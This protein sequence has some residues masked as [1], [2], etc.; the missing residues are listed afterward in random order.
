MSGKTGLDLLMKKIETVIG[1]HVDVMALEY[2]FADCEIYFDVD[3]PL[4]WG[5]IDPLTIRLTRDQDGNTVELERYNYGDSV[6]AAIGFIDGD[7]E[8]FDFKITRALSL[9]DELE[10][11][12]EKIRVKCASKADEK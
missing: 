4:E 7:D 8:K 6:L 1:G 10:K 9:A 3:Y 11:L 5:S 12:A 2:A